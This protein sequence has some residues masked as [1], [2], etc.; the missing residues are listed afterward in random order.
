MNKLIYRLAMML[1]ILAMF[2]TVIDLNAFNLSYYEKM[3]EQEKVAETL[4]LDDDTVMNATHIM[5]DYLKDRR[6]DMD[7]RMSDGSPYYSQRELD[8]MVDVKNLYQGALLFRNI[9]LLVSLSVMIYAV[10]KKSFCD[11]KE[12]STWSL[13]VLSVVFFALGLYA[14]V[15]FDRFWI[16][17]HEVFFTNDL[18]LLDP[19]VDRLISMVP[20]PFF[21]GLVLRIVLSLV[22][23]LGLSVLV[24]LYFRKKCYD[25]SRRITSN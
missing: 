15:D 22:L 17:F 8:H 5:L 3:Y 10:I 25:D 2:I 13:S 23:V 20:L 7:Y 14:W 19:A 1:F 6:T 4:G 11:L 9:A 12:A 18:W 24:Y 16:N 21:M